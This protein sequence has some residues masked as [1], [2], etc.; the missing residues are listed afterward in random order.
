MIIWIIIASLVILY[1]YL[2]K[3]QT[4]IG[5]VSDTAKLET[6]AN[7]PF[8]GNGPYVWPPLWFDRQRRSPSDRQL[9]WWPSNNQ[10]GFPI[11]WMGN[12]PL[13]LPVPK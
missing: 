6:V 13:P 12:G 7:Y 1:Q 10:M 5:G 2:T 8:Y 3:G 11:R 4:Q 9:Y